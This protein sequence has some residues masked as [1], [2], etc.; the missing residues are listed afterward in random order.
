[1]EG[2]GCKTGTGIINERK[3]SSQCSRALPRYTMADATMLSAFSGL[4][5]IGFPSCG[6]C[7]GGGTWS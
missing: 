1:M 4:P 7:D 5:A 2:T 3:L 6:W